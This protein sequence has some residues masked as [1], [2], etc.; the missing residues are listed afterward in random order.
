MIARLARLSFVR[1]LFGLR[2]RLMLLVLLSLGPAL[3]LVAYLS[4]QRS[5]EAERDAVG[6][7]AHVARMVEMEYASQIE[8]ARHAIAALAL[9]DDLRRGETQACERALIGPREMDH[10]LHGLGVTDLEGRLICAAAGTPAPAGE[11][12]ATI[13]QAKRDEI[14]ALGPY[15]YHPELRHGVVVLAFLLP[16]ATGKANRILFAVVDPLPRIEKILATSGLAPGTVIAV[17]DAARRVLLRYP[18]REHFTGQ[19]APES[20]V[21]KAREG[22]SAEALGIDGV[23]RL[24]AFSPLRY[25]GQPEGVHAQVGV[26]S[27]GVMDPVRRETRT[28]YVLLLAAAAALLAISWTVGGRLLVQPVRRLARLAHAVAEGDLAM[29][30]GMQGEAGEV[31]ELA[32]AFD[33]MANRLEQQFESL[34]ES[35]RVAA[36]SEK[37][38]RAVADQ[39]TCGILLHLGGKMVYANRSIEAMTG[40]THAELLNM[41]FWE[42]VRPD[43]QPMIRER[44]AR[45]LAGE[46][47]SDLVEFPLNT[48]DGSERWVASSGSTIVLDNQVG[49]LI[50]WWDITARRQAERAARE[51]EETLRAVMNNIFSVIMLHRGNKLIFVNDALVTATGRSREELL[52]MHY[53]D[54]FVPED[55]LIIHERGNKRLRGEEVSNHY[56]ARI[57]HRDGSCR[58]VEVGGTL[59]DYLGAPAVL[60]NCYDITERVRRR[61]MTLQ[62][63]HGSPS[64]TFVLDEEHRVRYW[65]AACESAF[66]VSAEEIVGTR[67]QW[68]PFY[69]EARPVLADVIL[70]GAAADQGEAYYAGKKLRPSTFVREAYEAEDFFPQFGM[71]GMWLHLTAAPLR[72]ADGKVVG[73]IETLLDVTDRRLAEDELRQTKQNLEVLVHKRTAQLA[74]AKETLEADNTLRQEAERV[75]RARNAELTELNRKLSEAQEQLLQS[76][77]LASI[78]QLAAGVAHEINNPIG[79]VHSNLGSLENYLKDLFAL[80]GQVEDILAELPESDALRR[81]IT[82]LRDQ[83]DLAFIREDLPALLDESK[84]GITRVKKIVQDLKDFSRVD[85]SQEWQLADLHSGIDSTLNIVRNE[86]KYKA[87]VVKE[88]GELPQVEC[89]LS[90]LNQVFMNLLVNAAHAMKDKERGTI[91]VRTGRD[92]EREVWVEIAD[93]GCGISPENLKRIFDPFFTTKP[94]GKGTGLGLSLAYGIVQ[95]HHGRIEVRSK[96]GEGT[97]FRVTLPVSQANA[98]APEAEAVT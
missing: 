90:Q 18:D 57:Q 2:G 67:E 16:P 24:W 9:L 25:A 88:Y 30:T 92:D 7:V 93:D 95:K 96:E 53:T 79:Y 97:T 72:D 87:D 68:R 59:I 52:G 51:G 13:E 64:P 47:I 31:G 38:F 6:D 40:Y 86:I 26:P 8:R 17:T 65:N 15:H 82:A 37:M 10:A 3:G 55:R 23:R 39:S 73:A 91:T 85:T 89:L 74:Q 60:G 14:I 28:A 34:A 11:D 56:E 45:R 42:A 83:F 41:Q 44:A 58:W 84:E 46:P 61:E 27:A 81:R 49:A 78:G 19:I 63:L 70:A 32:R 35:R 77:K 33:G 98:A 62:I 54:V 4:A 29:R 50:T 71:R 1:K 66:G 75:L 20:E 80:I 48:R 5:V 69:A 43:H 36:R 22:D 94:V 21:Y 12:M 76:E